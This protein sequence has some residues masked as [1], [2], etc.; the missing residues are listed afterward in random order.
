MAE[1]NEQL[2]INMLTKLQCD[3]EDLKNKR[4]ENGITTTKQNGRIDHVET[5]ITEHKLVH[6]DDMKY[7]RSINA[8]MWFIVVGIIAAVITAVL[9]GIV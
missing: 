2:I 1:Q 6:E 4:Y 9:R 8:K 5:W 3:V 7:R